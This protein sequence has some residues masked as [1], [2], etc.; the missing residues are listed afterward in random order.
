MQDYTQTVNKLLNLMGVR[1][2][3]LIS[4]QFQNNNQLLDDYLQPARYLLVT[5][6]PIPPVLRLYQ[7]FF[8][9]LKCNV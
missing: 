9:Y 2:T 5:N 1:K 4:P 8:P 6:T 3:I 7:G